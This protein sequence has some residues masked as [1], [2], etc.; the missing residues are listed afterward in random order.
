[1]KYSN[2]AETSFKNKIGRPRS[3]DEKRLCEL[4]KLYYS[5]AFSLRKLAKILGTSRSAIARAIDAEFYGHNCP[6][7]AR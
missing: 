4:I 2:N 1:M 3:L 5:T 7:V 6:E